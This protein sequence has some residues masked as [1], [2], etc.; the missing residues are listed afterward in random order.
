MDLDEEILKWSQTVYGVA[1]S[2]SIA[3]SL[4]LGNLSTLIDSLRSAESWNPSKLGFASCLPVKEF[5]DGSIKLYGDNHDEIF[6]RISESIVKILFI[7]FAVVSDACLNHLIFQ[8]GATPGNFLVNKVE[9]AKSKIDPKFHWAAN[10]MF[11]LAAIRNAL[12]HNNGRWNDSSIRILKQAGISEVDTN[13]AISLSFGDLFRYRR[14]F[15]T[16]IGELR[17]LIAGH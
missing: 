14:A 9:W 15:R 13:V 6:L 4:N 17:K 3:R 1:H 16:L 5:E 2:L 12:V 11:E 7:N 8:A 10:G